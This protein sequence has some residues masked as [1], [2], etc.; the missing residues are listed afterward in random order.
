M[1][2]SKRLN[3]HETS[4]FVV[5]RLNGLDFIDDDTSSMQTGILSERT[6]TTDLRKKMLKEQ[7]V[8]GIFDSMGQLGAQYGQLNTKYAGDFFAFFY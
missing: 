6:S 5:F 3:A 1:T 4:I 7:S 2:H 8:R